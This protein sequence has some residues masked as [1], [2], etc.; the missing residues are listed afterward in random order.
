MRLP[1]TARLL[2]GAVALVLTTTLV[3]PAAQAGPKDRKRKVDHSIS[4]L[5]QDLEDTSADLAKAY[6]RLKQIQQQL[7]GARAKLAAAQ[8]TL[9]A[10]KAKDVE[11]GQKLAVSKANE[12]KA[13]DELAANATKSEETTST[14]GGIARQAYQTS[15][16]GE[17]SVALDATSV[18]DLA[19]RMVLADTAMRI[20]GDALAELQALAAQTTATKARLVAVREQTAV[21]KKEAEAALARAR[22]AEKAAADAKAKVDALLADQK[23]QVAHIEARKAA[24][25]KRLAQ[26]EA[27]RRTLE[28]KLA[29][30]ARQ[31]RIRA[32]KSGHASSSSES[33]GGFLSRPVNGGWISS[34]FGMRYHPIL[35]YWRLH[36]GMDFA[37]AC[38]TPVHAA[39]SG[40]VVSAGWA[41][42]YGNRVVIDNGYVR[43]V[44]LSTTYNHLSRIVVHG[45]HVSRGQ[46]IAYSGTTGSSTGCHLHFETYENGV[47]KNP[48]RWL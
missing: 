21:L 20:Q 29:E 28:K 40:T 32:E 30:L 16:L 2:A 34:E 6:L 45:G 19:D 36:A 33:T 13:L 14:I 23:T 35:H 18:Q 24:E 26:L 41:G 3:A 46:L 25:K 1:R 44:G 38:G 12:Q 22:A 10:A 42:G 31:A 43:G 48:R 17:L 11:L 39:A 7:P 8:R 15:G 47:P 9:A 37:V 5:K 4:Q 27:E